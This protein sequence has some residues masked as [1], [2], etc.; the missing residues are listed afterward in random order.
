MD[1]EGQFKAT[2]FFQRAQSS[3]AAP[4]ATCLTVLNDYAEIE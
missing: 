3:R 4:L 1:E 2:A